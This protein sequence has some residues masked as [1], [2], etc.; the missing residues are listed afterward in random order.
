MLELDAGPVVGFGAESDLDLTGLFKIV[1]QLPG[2]T[3]VPAE[4]DAVGRLEDQDPGPPAFAAVY[5][6][7]VDV[8]ADVGFEHG[9]CDRRTQ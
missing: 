9:C 1:D 6:S 2:G 4:H 3:D 5:C 8:A 7:V